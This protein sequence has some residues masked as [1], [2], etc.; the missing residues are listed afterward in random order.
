MKPLL[1]FVG[2]FLFSLMGFSEEGLLA[3][4]SFSSEKRSWTC[5]GYCFLG[6]DMPGNPFRPISSTGATE[7]EARHNLD[8]DPYYQTGVTCKEIKS[9]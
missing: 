4:D 8:C 7:E 1:S 2:F 6:G 5:D 9:E 3:N